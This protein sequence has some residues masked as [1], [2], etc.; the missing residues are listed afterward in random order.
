MK[1]ARIPSAMKEQVAAIGAQLRTTPDVEFGEGDAKKPI[2]QVFRE[3]LQVLPA[4][5]SLERRPRAGARQIP[6]LAAPDRSPVEF[7]E[8]ADPERVALDKR[9]RKHASDN[10]MSYACCQRTHE[11]QVTQPPYPRSNTWDV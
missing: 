4:R 5:W 7:A 6:A 10:G 11:V 2:H 3:F 8:G 1:R 9:I